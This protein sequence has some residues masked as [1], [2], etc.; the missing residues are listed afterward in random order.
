MCE[1]EINNLWSGVPVRLF[2][3][4]GILLIENLALRQ[5]TAC[6]SAP[7]MQNIS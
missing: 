6:F 5:Q 1:S 7:D 2:R 4:R 3:S